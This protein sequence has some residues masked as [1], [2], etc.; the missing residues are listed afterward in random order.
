[1]RGHETRNPLGAG[2][3]SRGRDF[4]YANGPGHYAMPTA[5]RLP[6]YARAVEWRRHANRKAPSTLVQVYTGSRAMAM[7]A[8]EIDREKRLGQNWGV[9]Q[10]A[11]LAVLPFEANPGHF[12]WR[13]AEGLSVAIIECGDPETDT[14]LLAMVRL[15][16][17]A[18]ARVVSVLLSGGRLELFAPGPGGGVWRLN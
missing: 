5:K 1:M 6:P 17:E 12:D 14:T 15:L 3:Q 10:P 4:G 2:G 9:I 8:A 13:F 16:V 18:G 11:A 7:A